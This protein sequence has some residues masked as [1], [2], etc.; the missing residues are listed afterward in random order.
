MRDAQ[1]YAN[2]APCLD[3]DTLKQLDEATPL[4]EDKA[5]NRG[6]KHMHELLVSHGPEVLARA[7]LNMARIDVDPS[8][9]GGSLVPGKLL[10]QAH[11]V[12][13]RL[14]RPLSA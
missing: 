9:R 8:R 4:E 11:D 1:V 2:I 10:N 5:W 7:A 6:G 14:L 13:V 12:A 3:D